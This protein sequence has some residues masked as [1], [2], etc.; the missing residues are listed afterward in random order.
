VEA[1]NAEPLFTT[2][3]FIALPFVVV[4]FVIAVCGW[5]STIR[6]CL[7]GQPM[8]PLDRSTTTLGLVDVAVIFCFWA[9]SQVAIVV[10][11]V[12][13]AGPKIFENPDALTRDFGIELLLFSGFGQL[14]V[15]AIGVVYLLIRYRSA[16]SFGLR[17]KSLGRQ[18]LIGAIA[19]IMIFPIIMTVQW[20]LAKLVPYEH[21]VLEVLTENATPLSIASTWLAAVIA[22]PL[23]EEFFFR[24]VLHN[25]LERVSVSSM[26]DSKLVTGGQSHGT[27]GQDNQSPASE[28]MVA[29][30][31]EKSETNHRF[32]NGPQAK[33]SNPYASPATRPPSPRDAALSA[34]RV[35]AYWPIIVSSLFFAL[36]HVGQG[37]APIPLFILAVG[38]GY[39]FRQTGSFI[40]CWTMHLMLNFYSMLIFTIAILMGEAP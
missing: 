20:I 9:V 7:A 36:V 19:F 23:A 15:L 35:P 33:V 12:A 27:L 4:F 34:N 2:L 3:D 22:A 17:L 31:Q 16:G 26:A 8:I 11:L 5:V 1:S 37:L 13:M 24:G 30:G 39:V 6:K 10:G 25:W 40:A 38:L 32:E 28:A 29:A 18:I 14:A 21:A